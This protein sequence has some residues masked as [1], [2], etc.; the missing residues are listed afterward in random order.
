MVTKLTELL[1]QPSDIIG[2]FISVLYDRQAT[3]MGSNVKRRF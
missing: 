3:L 1:E 2:D